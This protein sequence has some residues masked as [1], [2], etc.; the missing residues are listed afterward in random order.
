MGCH[1]TSRAVTHRVA[2]RDDRRVGDGE[3][4]LVPMTKD[5]DITNAMK[6]ALADNPN[7]RVDPG[8]ERSGA[9]TVSCFAVA[10]RPTPGSLCVPHDGPRMGSPG[11]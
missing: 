9:V 7:Y 2:L 6:L 1:Q 5:R 11:Q 3:Q 8:F 4:L 10:A